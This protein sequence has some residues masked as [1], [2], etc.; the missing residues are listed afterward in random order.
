MSVRTW[1]VQTDLALTSLSQRMVEAGFRVETR[2]GSPTGVTVEAEDEAAPSLANIIGSFMFSEWQYEFIGARARSAHAYLTK[3]E[4]EYVCLLTYHSLRKSR[5]PIADLLPVQWRLQLSEDV[6]AVLAQENFLDIDGVVRFRA[7]SYLASIDEALNDVVEQFLTDREYEEFVSMLRFL[8]DA[9]PPTGDIAHV[10]CSDD[11]V[12][13][14]DDCGELLRDTQVLVAAQQ[15]SDDGEVDAEDLAM[16]ILITRSPHRIVIHDTTERAPWPSFSETL[17]R[18]FLERVQ[19]C[20]GCAHCGYS[21][22]GSVADGTGRDSRDVTVRRRIL[23]KH[24][25]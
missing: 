4:R 19:R 20:E 12:W 23:D 15:A 25:E 11:K 22:S 10:Y 21:S 24:P 13:L 5:E 17:E 14:T 3:D 2:D 16:S 7:R 6:E 18:V 8:L 1:Q 9:Q